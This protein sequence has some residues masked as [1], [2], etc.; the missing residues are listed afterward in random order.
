MIGITLFLHET[1]EKKKHTIDYAGAFYLTVSV[2]G[3]MIALV[4]GGTRWAWLSYQSLGLLLLSIIV[5]VVFL[6]RAKGSRTN[7]ALFYLANLVPFLLQMLH[8]S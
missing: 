2:S 4:E 7:D 1:V 6:S 5:F 3:L 8:R